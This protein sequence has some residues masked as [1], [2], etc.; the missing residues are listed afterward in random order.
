MWRAVAVQ[1]TA[2]PFGLA[3]PSPHGSFRGSKA[4]R[5]NFRDKIKVLKNV[6]EQ[7]SK[8]G[9]DGW[10]KENGI[11]QEDISQEKQNFTPVLRK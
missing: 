11:Q 5:K 7:C 6:S 2:S 1:S 3:S 4:D 8:L 10:S 9:V